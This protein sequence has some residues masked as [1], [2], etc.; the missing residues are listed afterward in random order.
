MPTPVFNTAYSFYVSLA[1][2]LDPSTFRVNPTIALGDFKISIDGSAFTNLTNTP[3]T[4]PV[5][6]IAVLVTLTDAEM[7]G[8]KVNIQAIDAAGD[9]WEEVL[10]S[11]D[12]PTASTETI[13]DIQEGDRVESNVSLRINRKGTTDPVLD[14]SITG[15]LLSPSVSLQTKEKP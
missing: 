6:G 14:K 4:D 9:E 10:I 15:S 11:I 2:A 5:G 12:V 7:D 8:E 1:D 13:N 3:V